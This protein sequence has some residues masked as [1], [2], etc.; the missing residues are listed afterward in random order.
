[1]KTQPRALGVSGRAIGMVSCGY[2][3]VTGV[4]D[5]KGDAELVQASIVKHKIQRSPPWLEERKH[6][7]YHTILLKVEEDSRPG[8]NTPKE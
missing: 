2:R 3:M 6:P 4:Y 7:L 8:G 1:M 5:F